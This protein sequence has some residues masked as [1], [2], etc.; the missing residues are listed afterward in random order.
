MEMEM[1]QLI[2]TDIQYWIGMTYSYDKH[3]LKYTTSALPV[4]YINFHDGIEERNPDP[5]GQNQEK[6]CVVMAYMN[7]TWAWLPDYCVNPT[8]NHVV[9]VT[10]KNDDYLL[11][12]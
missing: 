6:D 12:K 11:F 7:E 10:N 3:V 1:N 4:N 5:Y 2:P 9:C 8:K